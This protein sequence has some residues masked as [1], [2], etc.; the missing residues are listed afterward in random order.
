MRTLSAS[1]RALSP[2]TWL[3]FLGSVS[4]LFYFNWFDVYHNHFFSTGFTVIFYQLSRIFFIFCLLWLC[5]FTG[6]RFLSLFATGTKPEEL[7][8]ALLAFFSGVGIW[9][10]LMFG[11]GLAGLDNRYLLMASTSLMF[12]VSLPTL[13]KRLQMVKSHPIYW[14]GIWVL[15]IPTTLF[16]ITK[17]LY[18]AGGHDYYTHYFHFYRSVTQAGNI[19]PNEVWYHFYY[20][21]GA[22]LFFLS[23]LLTD[24]LAPQ[25]VSTAML[26]A[27]GGLVF[28]F[29]KNAT[30]LRL[31]PWIGAALYIGFLIYTPGQD[32]NLHHGGWGD[33]EKIHELVGVL[34]FA[35]IW[36]MCCLQKNASRTMGITLLLTISALVLLIPVFTVF[37]VAYLLLML[38]YFVLTKRKSP[39]FWTFIGLIVAGAWFVSILIINYLFSGLPDDQLVFIFGLIFG[40]KP[41]TNGGYC[42][43]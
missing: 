41:L 4:L 37:V 36:M 30:P 31:F 11:L 43:N 25:L 33:L 2:Q 24:P 6:D 17:G 32:E 7:T 1:F 39:A 29:L 42:L 20:S 22:G 21:K 12:F 3:L 28:S 35:V 13:D 26:V 16:I 38:T 15:I 5:Y 18:P 40:S 9:Q 10:I 34:V 14:P 19:W 23:M 8:A 27:G